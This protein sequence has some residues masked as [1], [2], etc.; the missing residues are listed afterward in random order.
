MA[1]KPVVQI[2][3]PVG[4]FNWMFI[5]GE[6]RENDNGQMR[7]SASV[8]FESMTPKL[9]DFISKLDAFWAENKPKGA[10]KPK[11]NGVYQEIKLV[12]DTQPEGFRLSQ[13][14][15]GAPLDEDE[16]A[17]GRFIISAW[18]GVEMPD[19]KKKHVLTFNAKG[20]KVDLGERKLGNGSRGALKV[21]GG[22]YENG[23][24]KG[25]SLYLNGVIISKF[26]EYV[27]ETTVEAID[28][29]EDEDA[30]DGS[31][32]NEAGME[33][34]IDDDVAPKAKVTL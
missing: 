14:G 26:V 12:D 33:P 13:K 23:T 5:S 9:K 24:N 16:E 8:Y 11:S 31:E 27:G 17:T 7:Y 1:K 18:T 10:R 22:I 30:W 4:D 21:A 28:E 25:I 2:Q 3:T 20:T 19:G 34:I 15:Y 32:L 6:G 29:D